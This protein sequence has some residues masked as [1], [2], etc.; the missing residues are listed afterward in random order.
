MNKSRNLCFEINPDE[1]ADI[2]NGCD[3]S[4]SDCVEAIIGL[5]RIVSKDE[6][7]IRC[8]KKDNQ[9]AEK[10][11]KEIKGA[12]V[13]HDRQITI[14]QRE[15]KKENQMDNTFTVD[16][17]QLM[18]NAISEKMKSENYKDNELTYKIDSLSNQLGNV[19]NRNNGNKEKVNIV[20]VIW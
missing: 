7:A 16:Q 1:I 14:L 17:M 8:L 13:R 3:I 5:S 6:A 15:G 11:V 10:A 20:L 18:L 12:I 9:S 2:M 19:V 4:L